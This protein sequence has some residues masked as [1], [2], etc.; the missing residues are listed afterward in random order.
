MNFITNKNVLTERLIRDYELY[1]GEIYVGVDF[2][3]TIRDYDTGD[4]ITP[5]YEVLRDLQL[6]GAQLCLYT[7]REGKDLVYAEK[8][9]SGIGLDIEHSNYSPLMPQVRK[10]LFNI[11]LDD[12]A[13]LNEALEACKNLINYIKNK[14]ECLTR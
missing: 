12:R 8:F 13:G 9:C 7:A 10:P 3:D 14:K 4:V 11:L 1:R 6:Y 2:D 5:V